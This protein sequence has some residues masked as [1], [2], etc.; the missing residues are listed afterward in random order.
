MYNF[1]FGESIRSFCI[2]SHIDSSP[3]QVTSQCVSKSKLS[4]IFFKFVT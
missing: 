3:S 1:W 2:K 4:Y